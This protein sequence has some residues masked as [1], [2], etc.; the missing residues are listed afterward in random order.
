LRDETFQE[1]KETARKLMETHG[2]SGLS[3]RAIGR[4]MRM[5]ATALYRYYDSLDD[6]ITDLIVDN[7]NALAD[8][9]E[10]ARNQ[11]R[12]ANLS[13]GEQLFEVVQAYRRYAINNPIDFQ[14]IYGNPIPGYEAPRERTLPPANRAYELFTQLNLEAIQRGETTVPADCHHIPATVRENLLQM[15][16][17]EVD[18]QLLQALYFT[19]IGWGQMHGVI[20]LELFNHIQPVVGDM[21]AFYEARMRD[22]FRTMGLE[23]TD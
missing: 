10:A 21:D 9:L 17:G 14:L 12:D 3:V 11:A 8:T 18:E 20:M 19:A 16:D 15:V 1:I 4:E 13:V 5:S 6:L 7:Y 2:T 23:L 22:M